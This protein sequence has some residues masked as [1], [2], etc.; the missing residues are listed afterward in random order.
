MQYRLIDIM[1][2][3]FTLIELLIVITIIGILIAVLVPGYGFIEARSRLQNT[4]DMVVQ[5]IGQTRTLAT[6]GYQN[7]VNSNELAAVGIYMEQNSNVV[8]VFQSPLPI[9]DDM[10]VLFDP[11][12]PAL[13]IY[14]MENIFVR[15]IQTTKKMD[16]VVILFSPPFGEAHVLDNQSTGP[17]FPSVTIEIGVG[18]EE[19]ILKKTIEFNA[20]TN[21]IDH[22]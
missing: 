20:L 16:N 13:S 11:K 7:N 5:M 4:L 1:K 14:N 15:H 19:N 17:L 21:R 22:D 12:K 2:K 6:T 10:S 3:A 18:R 9:S 8:Y